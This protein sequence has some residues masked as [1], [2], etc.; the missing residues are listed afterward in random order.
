[1]LKYQVNWQVFNFDLMTIVFVTGHLNAIINPPHAVE[2]NFIPPSLRVADYCCIYKQ[3]TNKS[4]RPTSTIWLIDEVTYMSNWIDLIFK[5]Y[6]H[7]YILTIL[8]ID[9]IHVSLGEYTFKR[10]M[11]THILYSFIINIPVC[12]IDTSWYRTQSTNEG[13]AHS[14]MWTQLRQPSVPCS[15]MTNL[16]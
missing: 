6:V 13:H 11:V 12:S 3:V 10:L 8:K 2:E 1:M 14:G 4:N 15:P 7:L 5:R 16:W 9:V